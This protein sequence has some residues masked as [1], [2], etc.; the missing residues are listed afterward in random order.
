MN[1]GRYLFY[2]STLMQVISNSTVRLY[3]GLHS[4]GVLLAT[5][6]VDSLGNF[7]TTEV[8]DFGNGLHK[9]VEG[10]KIAA[11]MGSLIPL[12]AYSSCLALITNRIWSQ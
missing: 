3:D 8:L 7:Y 5:I 1:L 12:G 9:E 4:T 2:D 11:R 10:V 6:E